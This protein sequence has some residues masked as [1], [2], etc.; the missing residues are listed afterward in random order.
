MY[1]EEGQKLYMTENMTDGFLQRWED[2]RKWSFGR[3]CI[4]G[5]EQKQE[6]MGV[7]MWRG[8]EVPQECKDHPQFEY[9]RPRK[10]D[11]DKNADDLKLL[12]EFWGST[13]GSKANGMECLSC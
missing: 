3:I 5:T 2:F 10:M 12:R 7:V 4:L 1:G 8:Q 9:Y 6:I 13:D 11:I